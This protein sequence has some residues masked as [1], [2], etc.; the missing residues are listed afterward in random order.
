MTEQITSKSCTQCN[1][2]KPLTQFNKDKGHKDG[3]RSDCKLCQNAHKKRYRQTK[4]GKAAEIAYRQT[5]KAKTYRKTYQYLWRQNDDGKSYMTNY[6]T[7][8]R[9]TQKYKESREKSRKRYRLK[10]KLKTKARNAVSSAVKLGKIQ[11][12]SNFNCFY[13]SHQAA[14]YHHWHGYD[15]SHWFDIIPVCRD[16]HINTH[17]LL[18][19]PASLP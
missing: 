4:Q 8:Y 11:P 14:E 13:C 19:C 7:K 16:C 9:Q 12:A 3:R 10:N 6:M 1:L 18:M 15:Q 2:V 17:K 5:E